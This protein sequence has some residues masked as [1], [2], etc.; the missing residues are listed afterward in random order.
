KSKNKRLIYH[1]KGGLTSSKPEIS[2]FFY[3]SSSE[4]GKS[5][6]SNEE[7]RTNMTALV[8][9]DGFKFTRFASNPLQRTREL[10][11]V[12]IFFPIFME[13]QKYIHTYINIY[14]R[15]DVQH[16]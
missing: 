12:L 8:I 6:K 15:K 16:T 5:L 7:G 11:Y 4:E 1:I 14:F 13:L 10:K 2:I 3:L 9:N